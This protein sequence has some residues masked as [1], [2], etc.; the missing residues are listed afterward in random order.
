[1]WET[2]CSVGGVEADLARA[3]GECDSVAGILDVLAKFVLT[4][5]QP[6]TDH[7][8]RVVLQQVCFFQ[9]WQSSRFHRRMHDHSA[10]LPLAVFEPV[11]VPDFPSTLLL[12]LPPTLGGISPTSVWRYI[13]RRRSYWTEPSARCCKLDS[14]DE[15]GR[16]RFPELAHC[17]KA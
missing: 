16:T 4:P 2:R 13:W 6:A 17:C 7:D 14:I 10:F 15:V 8:Q 9:W 3:F 5:R 1:M 11:V 12:S